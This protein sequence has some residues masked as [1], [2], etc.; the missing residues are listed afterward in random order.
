MEWTSL[1]LSLV[2][3]AN[4]VIL[5]II[6][7]VFIKTYQKTKAHASI[8]MIVFASLMFLH[9]IVG[10]YSQF[11]EQLTLMLHIQQITS[12]TVF[13]YDLVIRIAELAGLLILLKVIWD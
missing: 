6:I 4:M 9:N 1:T 11:D 2:S 10:A 13:Q 12:A 8:G 3:I 7:S 5:G